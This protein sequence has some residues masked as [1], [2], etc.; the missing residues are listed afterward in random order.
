MRL[1]Y[2]YNI[3][4]LSGRLIGLVLFERKK[5][6]NAFCRAFVKPGST[7]QH[8]KFK[9]IKQNMGA[10]WRKCSVAFKGDLKK[11]SR[12]RIPYCS[13]DEIPVYGY[14]AYFIKF[15]Y[16][17]CA[18]KP[19]IDLKT[20]TKEELEMS[21]CPVTVKNMI[22]EGYIPAIENVEELINEW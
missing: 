3:R 12:L 17:Y 6:K 11:Y 15:L 16:K 20:V 2:R 21:G 7:E 1:T 10:I 9:G 19:E 8:L 18:D 14:Y 13:R 4:S 22:E 5:T